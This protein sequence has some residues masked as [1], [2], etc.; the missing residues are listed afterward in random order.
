VARSLD[1]LADRFDVVIGGRGR[2]DLHGE[3][4]LDLVLRILPQRGLDLGRTNRAIPVALQA[5][6]LDAHQ[7]RCVAPA[8]G[9]A[10]ALQHQ[11]LVAA[12]QHISEGRLPG[13][14]TIGNVNICP[15]F[16]REDCAEIVEQPVSELHHGVG[17]DIQRR[18]M[19]GSQ[20]FVWHG[21]RAGDGE[22]FTTCTN[23][24]FLSLLNASA[25]VA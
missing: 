18:P 4:G 11:D 22:K 15:A 24:H 2:V 1:C 21:G 8:D 10:T 17:I 12:R 7:A 25:I 3:H 23:D 6:D 5:L 9:E 19:H 14:M 16:G 13:A 20:H